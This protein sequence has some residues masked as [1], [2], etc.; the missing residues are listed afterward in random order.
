MSLKSSK[1]IDTNR[2][3]LEITIDGEKFGQAVDS[4]IRTQSKKI[5]IPGFRKGK[6]P[7]SFIKKYYGEE[8]F[9]EEAL[10]SLYNDA[11]TE[12]ADEAKLTIVDDKM[13]FDLVSIGK[14]GVEFKVA[15]TVTPEVKIGNYKGL[16]AERVIATVTDEEVN[17][18]VERMADRNA[19]ME[20]VEGRAAEMG[21]I[22]VIDFEGF[23]DGVAFEGGKAEGYSLSL[24]AGQFIPGF[25]EQVAGHNIDEEFD[26]N[27]TFP[28][29]YQAEELKGKAAVFKIKLHEIKHRELPV[30]D[31]EFAKDV[32]EFDTLDALKEDIKAK[33]LERKK[34]LNENDVENQIIDELIAIME[35]EIPAAMIENRVNQNLQDFDYRL[36]SQGMNLDTYIKYTG[37]GIDALK[38]NFRPQAERQVKLRLALEKIV[39]LE[40]IEPTAEEIEEQFTKYAEMYGVEVDKVK[41]VIRV[42]DVKADLATEKA[43]AFVKDNASVKDVEAKT[44]KV[45]KKTA[46]KKTTT[47]STA[48]KADGEKMTATKSTTTKKA[49]STTT[50]KTTT[51]TTKKTT[52]AKKTTKTEE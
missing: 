42:Q 15:L 35:A 36:Q 33:S 37:A 49:A 4:V 16:K 38:D 12:A 44:E 52:T 1:K 45:E 43:I 20:S 22:A 13:D 25:E 2:Y 47:K 46:A 14:D 18:E 11:L 3:E 10:N 34:N 9:Y 17:A 6:A 30:I 32:S 50:K 21:D 48:A 26:V 39:E 8:A 41:A 51:S 19:R 5:N 31:D 27:V 24:G 40:N 23:V 29:D 7:I 28:E